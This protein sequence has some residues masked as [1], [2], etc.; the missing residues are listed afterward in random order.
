MKKKV[1]GNF[2]PRVSVK[3]QKSVRICRFFFFFSISK[4]KKPYI[5]LAL[6]VFKLFEEILK[7]DLSKGWIWKQDGMPDDVTEGNGCIEPLSVVWQ[8]N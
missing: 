8:N 1:R 3:C 4:G 2:Y 5:S 7:E 6:V